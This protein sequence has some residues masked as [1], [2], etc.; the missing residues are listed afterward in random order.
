MGKNQGEN[1]EFRGR[2]IAA[3]VR[4]KGYSTEE[5]EEMKDILE[6]MDRRKK[7]DKS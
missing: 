4:M 3:S 1:F 7:K 6:R 2:R 5:I